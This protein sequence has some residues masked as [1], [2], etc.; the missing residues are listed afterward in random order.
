M[1]ATT[2]NIPHPGFHMVQHGIWR[3]TFSVSLHRQSLLFLSSFDCVLFAYCSHGCK[4]TQFFNRTQVC[5]PG[6]RQQVAQVKIPLWSSA[7]ASFSPFSA[8]TACIH[9]HLV[10]RFVDFIFIHITFC[11]LEDEI[12]LYKSSIQLPWS[13]PESSSTGDTEMVLLATFSI[14]PYG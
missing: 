13:Q 1:L 3:N 9:R 10:F 8:H 5:Q 7:A 12:L 14:G 6:G 2:G 4:W 11:V